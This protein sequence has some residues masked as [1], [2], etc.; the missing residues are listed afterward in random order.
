MTDQSPLDDEAEERRRLI[1]KFKA[2]GNK[3]Y[4]RAAACL[5]PGPPMTRW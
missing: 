1:D 3:A 4:L 2:T 5:M